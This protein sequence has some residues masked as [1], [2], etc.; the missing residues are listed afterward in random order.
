LPGIALCPATGPVPGF[1]SFD[2][3]RDIKWST[4]TRLHKVHGAVKQGPK[5]TRNR[6]DQQREAQL[7]LRFWEQATHAG[8]KGDARYTFV[9]AAL[10]WDPRTDNRKL[11]KLVRA[12]QG[13]LD[14]PF[15]S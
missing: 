4:V 11:R 1:W 6:L 13:R 12:G 7:A 8:L 3:K 9:K 14:H 5:S 15:A 10:N 2:P